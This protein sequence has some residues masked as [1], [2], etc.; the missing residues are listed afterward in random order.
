MKEDCLPGPT[1]GPGVFPPTKVWV[2]DRP[3]VEG[4][5]AGVGV[6]VGE[7]GE[8]I[9]EDFFI[10]IGFSDS[11]TLEELLP[12]LPILPP[13]LLIPMILSPPDPS[14][15]PLLTPSKLLIY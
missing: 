11:F 14:R 3:L 2:L 15:L 1:P 10:F 7:L 9:T 4:A 13:I 12:K 6:G 8:D 5:G